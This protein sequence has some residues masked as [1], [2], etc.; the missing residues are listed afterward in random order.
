MANKKFTVA[1][2]FFTEKKQIE[3]KIEKPIPT[4]TRNT[5]KTVF[6]YVQKK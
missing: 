4:P 5:K 6:L 1:S 2:E 3:D